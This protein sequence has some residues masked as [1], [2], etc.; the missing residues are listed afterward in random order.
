M[1]IR[2]INSTTVFGMRAILTSRRLLGGVISKVQKSRLFGCRD[3]TYSSHDL[4]LMTTEHWIENFKKETT[5]IARMDASTLTYEESANRMRSLL[6]TGIL[7]HDDITNRPER[8]FLAHRLLA[9]HSPQLGPGFWIRFTVHYN[10]CI[11]T[12]NG[13]GSAEQINEANQWQ[14]KGKLGC[15]GLT[16]KFAGVNSGLVVNTIAEYDHKTD[17]FLLN[18]PNEGE[19]ITLVYVY[20]YE[21]ICDGKYAKYDRN[22][23][24]FY[25]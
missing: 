10:L 8:F 24:L 14:E 21:Y 16:E 1:K 13:L 22:N 19:Y 2:G 5:D 23:G 17:S 18:S 15:F 25:I 6:Q 4:D 11:G 3:Y 7:R 20:M 12:I 9:F